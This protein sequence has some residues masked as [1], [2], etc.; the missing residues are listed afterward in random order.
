MEIELI[1]NDY[2]SKRN[3]AYCDF[4]FLKES[5]RLLLACIDINCINN[6][7][8]NA[9]NKPCSKL[10]KE[11]LVISKNI[12]IHPEDCSCYL[13]CKLKVCSCRKN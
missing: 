6:L 13:C 2:I 1:N 4:I 3:L 12:I 7:S 10:Y 9:R 11:V 8:N 5:C